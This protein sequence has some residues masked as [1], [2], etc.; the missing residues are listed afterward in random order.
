ML[1]VVSGIAAADVAARLGVDPRESVPVR[2]DNVWDEHDY[3]AVHLAAQV[4][5][6]DGHTVIIEP[7]GWL[8]T[9]NTRTERVSIGGSLVSVYWNVNALM[10]VIVAV[11]GRIV[12]SFDPLLYEQPAMGEPLPEETDLPFGEPGSCQS[13]A[14]ELQQRLTRLKITTRWLLDQPHPTWWGIPT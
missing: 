13:A 11:N 8:M 12:R 14:A 1:T 4:D 5:E 3:D 6:L 9:A 2:F 7:N 10:R